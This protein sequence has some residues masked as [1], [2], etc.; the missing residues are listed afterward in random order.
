MSARRSWR[1]C[2]TARPSYNGSL[3][4]TRSH[5]PYGARTLRH[6][7]THLTPREA[8]RHQ[9]AAPP[10]CARGVFKVSSWVTTVLHAD[11]PPLR[12]VPYT[13]I[14]RSRPYP[15]RF[16]S[17]LEGTVGGKSGPTFCAAGGFKYSQF[18]V[19]LAHVPIKKDLAL[20]SEKVLVH[21]YMGQR[22]HEPV[23]FLPPR[24]RPPLN[25]CPVLWPEIR[26]R[27]ILT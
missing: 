20:L 4:L 5:W 3:T 27:Y 17:S 10:N 12:Q 7:P 19:F 18:M 11:S 24:K 16:S 8:S 15:N 26:H 22:H 25:M 23:L 9:K 21:R 6:A 13:K 2:P 1:L 14:G